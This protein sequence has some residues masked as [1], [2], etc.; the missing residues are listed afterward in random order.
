MKGRRKNPVTAG[1]SR[2]VYDL[3][4]CLDRALCQQAQRLIPPALPRSGFR[5]ALKQ[6][7]RLGE[8]FK[9][10]RGEMMADGMEQPVFTC[11]PAG[12]DKLAAA[13]GQG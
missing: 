9:L 10:V 12:L 11:R 13:L 4:A 2:R 8:L 7:D 6:L 3:A 1:E 5:Q